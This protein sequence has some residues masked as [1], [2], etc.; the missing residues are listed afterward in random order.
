MRLTRESGSAAGLAMPHHSR[1]QIGIRFVA[2]PALD[3]IAARR[4]S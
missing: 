1:A 4:E 3:A 2:E